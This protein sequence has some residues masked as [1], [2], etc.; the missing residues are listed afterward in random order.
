MF[1]FIGKRL[2][3]SVLVIFVIITVTFFMVRF[4]PGDPFSAE[5]KMPEFI[6]QRL[7]EHYGLNDPVLVR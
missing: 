3:Q 6:K 2:I 4:A 5:R 7:M 1:K